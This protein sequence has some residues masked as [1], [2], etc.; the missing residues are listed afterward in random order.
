MLSDLRPQLQI[1]ARTNARLIAS[2]SGCT[3]CKRLANA[4]LLQISYSKTILSNIPPENITLIP[5]SGLWA[6]PQHPD[7]TA[8]DAERHNQAAAA[9][10]SS[11]TQCKCLV[12]NTAPAAPQHQHQWAASFVSGRTTAEKSDSSL[13]LA[14]RR[15]ALHTRRRRTGGR[16]D[17]EVGEGAGS[18][19]RRA[20]KEGSMKGTE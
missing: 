14:R 20:R 3:F 19:R 10:L 13:T 16:G 8:P 2:D 15:S 9:E 4:Y 5:A 11:L 17:Q 1:C 7:G 6:L 18:G 12:R